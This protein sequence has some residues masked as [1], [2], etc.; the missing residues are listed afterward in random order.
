MRFGT[1][2]SKVFFTAS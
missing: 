1:F 2:K